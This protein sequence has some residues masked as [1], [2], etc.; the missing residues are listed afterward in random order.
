MWPDFIPAD[1]FIKKC[2]RFRRHYKSA[3]AK[4]KQSKLEAQDATAIALRFTDRSRT[5]QTV[6]EVINDF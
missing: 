6:L 2:S 4:C 1:E 3:T 5:T